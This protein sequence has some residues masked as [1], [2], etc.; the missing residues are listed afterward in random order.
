MQTYG[1][2]MMLENTG[3]FSKKAAI[4]RAIRY[5]LGGSILLSISGSIFISV[6]G[7]KNG[8]DKLGIEPLF[9][10]F[11]VFTQGDVKTHIGLTFP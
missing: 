11:P 5:F 9:Y 10:G 3:L 1:L 6:E 8:V 4:A 2:L 7:L